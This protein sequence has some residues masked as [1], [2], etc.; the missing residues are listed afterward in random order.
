MHSARNLTG[1]IYAKREKIYS[2]SGLRQSND[3]L[4]LENAKL[5]NQLAF[6]RKKNPLKDTS[7][8]RMVAN[9]DSIRQ[10]V[11][12]KYMPS[13]VLNNTTDLKN[14]YITLDLGSKDGVTRNMSV[15][16]AKGIVGKI[17]HVSK[18]YSLA[19]SILSSRTNVSC[20]IPDGTLAKVYW[21]KS[22]DPEHVLLS[23][24]PQS[25]KIKKGDTITTSGY[26]LFPENIMIGTIVGSQKGGTTGLNQYKVKLSTNFRKLHFV[27]VIN[28]ISTFERKVLEDSVATEQQ[29]VISE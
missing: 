6:Q 25:V 4:M 26:S 11:F 19:S 5:R 8:S 15:I 10:S 14:N 18:N 23:G 27:Y 29:E 12:Y 24:L 2:Y 20:V 9:D 1:G 3:S 21:G 22:F 16:S 13:R 17:T 28:D 7:Y